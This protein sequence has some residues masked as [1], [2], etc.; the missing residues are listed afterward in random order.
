MNALEG[1]G[2]LW[3]DCWVQGLLIGEIYLILLIKYPCAIHY[4]VLQQ[5]RLLRLNHAFLHP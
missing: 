2:N 3:I 1:E 5:E 4:H